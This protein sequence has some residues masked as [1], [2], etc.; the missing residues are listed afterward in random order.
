MYR[1]PG[2]DTMKRALITLA[3]LACCVCARYTCEDL[4][5]GYQIVLD[6]NGDYRWRSK[7]SHGWYLNSRS[8][9]TKGE[10]MRRAISFAD[11]E[12]RNKGRKT[13]VKVVCE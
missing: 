9:S 1:V 10:A 12:A 11:F 6:A 3:L 4:P 7:E 13:I 8:Y 5:E 2:G